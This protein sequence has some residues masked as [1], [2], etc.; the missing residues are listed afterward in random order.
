MTPDPSEFNFNISGRG[1]SVPASVCGA[2]NLRQ[3]LYRTAATTQFNQ[4]H[5]INQLL[6]GQ[7][8]NCVFYRITEE[9]T[10]NSSSGSRSA[11]RRTHLEPLPWTLPF[12]IINDPLG[13][14]TRQPEQRSGK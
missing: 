4:S 1:Y 7:D 6:S 11:C 10:A 14:A 5:T 12:D 8:A 13:S 2:F 3:K 9:L